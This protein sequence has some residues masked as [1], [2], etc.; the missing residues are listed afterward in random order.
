M[1]VKLH[2]S[3]KSVINDL[4][5]TFERY[6]VVISISSALPTLAFQFMITVATDFAVIGLG[7]VIIDGFVDF[8]HVLV[9][10]CGDSSAIISI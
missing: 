8:F 10:A 9:W 2:H 4:Y 3:V 6:L 1:F 5:L 7:E